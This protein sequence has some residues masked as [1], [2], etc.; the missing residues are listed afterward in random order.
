MSDFTTQGFLSDD[1]RNGVKRLETDFSALWAEARVVNEFAQA[2]QYQ[3]EIHKRSLVE[4]LAAVM[5]ARALST[6]QGVLVVLERGMEQQAK[7]LLRCGFESVFPLVAI[8]KDAGFAEKL[9]VSEELERLKGL[10][11]LIRYWERSGDKDGQL[12]DA[13]ALAAELKGQL[14]KV[15]GKKMSIV[16]AAEAAGLVDWYDTA[17]SF[18]S[19]TVHSSIRSLEEHLHIGTDGDVEAVKNEPSFEEAGKLLVTGMESMF[20]A[21]RAAAEVF[22]KDVGE[23]VERSSERVREAHPAS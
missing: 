22:G 4:M 3:L 14:A 11:K 20:H 6:Y 2:F 8:S 19:N 1:A 21:L 5:Y 23:F 7:M 10:N 15:D 13:R 17:Y 9:L 16:D 12:E 18:L